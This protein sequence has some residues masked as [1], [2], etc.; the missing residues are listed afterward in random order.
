MKIVGNTVGT[1][2]PRPDWNQND[3]KKGSFIRNKPKTFESDPGATF[4]PHVDENGNLS[5]TNDHDLPNPET[6][7]ITGPQGPQGEKGDTG[8]QGPQGEKGEKGDKGADGTMI[9][10]DL[11][12]RH[13]PSESRQQGMQSHPCRE[14]YHGDNQ[15]QLPQNRG[16]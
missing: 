15:R 11:T 8:P 1:T 13:S 10:E 3:P 12:Q 4:T 7:N 5:W 16:T 6:V 14:P 2:M 9:F